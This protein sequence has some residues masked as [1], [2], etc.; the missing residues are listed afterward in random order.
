LGDR[1]IKLNA[2][3]KR[4]SVVNVVAAVVGHGLSLV[5]NPTFG[6]TSNHWSGSR[7]GEVV[8]KDMEV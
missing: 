5:Q 3:L 2:A 4:R 1:G 8:E 6:L 7:A